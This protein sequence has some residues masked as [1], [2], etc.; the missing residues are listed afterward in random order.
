MKK[1]KRGR[2]LSRVVLLAFNREDL[3][4]FHL[5]LDTFQVIVNDLSKLTAELKRLHK[6]A[7]Q[8]ADQPSE[9]NDG[10][11]ARHRSRSA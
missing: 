3:L 2:P 10:K 7:Q 9:T 1:V 6:V 8:P 11:P 4:R 5:C